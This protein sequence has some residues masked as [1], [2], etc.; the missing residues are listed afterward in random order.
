MLQYIPYFHED[1]ITMTTPRSQPSGSSRR[2]TST[3]SIDLTAILNDLR[4]GHDSPVNK[5]LFPTHK[6]PISIDLEGATPVVKASTCG[7]RPVK[8]GS[9]R[10]PTKR[11]RPRPHTPTVHPKL[12]PGEPLDFDAFDLHKP[13]LTST[14]WEQFRQIR[15]KGS[16]E[17]CERRVYCILCGTVDKQTGSSTTNMKRHTCVKFVDD[18]NMR[19]PLITQ[20]SRDKAKLGLEDRN[21]L[22]QAA[23]SLLSATSSPFLL[24]ECD[25]MKE[26]LGLVSSLTLK[27]GKHI[28]IAS[29]LAGERHLRRLV[30]ETS[31]QRTELV[32]AHLKVQPEPY[33]VSYMIV[34]TTLTDSL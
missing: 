1:F 17:T 5:G 22:N 30:K 9:S 2:Q 23:V 3:P 20:F 15:V 25:E 4:Q 19:Q 26:L 7:K 10:P 13:D 12:R 11:R 27:L 33:Q 28:D 29:S 8:S 16:V 32:K 31:L 6:S 18:E 21:T 34:S 24:F 14:V